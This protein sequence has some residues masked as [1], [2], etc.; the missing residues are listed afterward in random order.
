MGF[1]HKLW[2][3]TLA[4]P[5]PDT[6]LGKL[7]KYDSFSGTPRSPPVLPV[8]VPI[9]RSIT[10]IRTNS[11]FKSFSSDLDPHSG[12]T[13]PR[14]PSTPDTPDGDFKKFTRRKSSAQ[15][16]ERAEPRR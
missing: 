3:E 7:R 8:E 11:N 14:T 16:L 4:G 9:T 2:D 13:T 5:A 15:A 10:I 1:L 12:S 6:G